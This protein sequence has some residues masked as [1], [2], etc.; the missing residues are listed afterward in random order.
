MKI[1]VMNSI[2]SKIP[3]LT[4]TNSI[5]LLYDNSQTYLGILNESVTSQKFRFLSRSCATGNNFAISGSPIPEKLSKC[6]VLQP[7]WQRLSC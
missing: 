2:A 4:A 6:D 5:L 3:I 1:L 7:V